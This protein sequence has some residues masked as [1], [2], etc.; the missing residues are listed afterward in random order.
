[1]PKKT[2]L[3]ELLRLGPLR[4]VLILRFSVFGKRLLVLPGSRARKRFHLSVN[5]LTSK[6]KIQKLLSNLRL[7]TQKQ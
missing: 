6:Q 7:I 3:L 2:S 5:F 1:M 4:V